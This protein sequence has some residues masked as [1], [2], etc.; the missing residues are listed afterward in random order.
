MANKKITDLTDIG[1][2]ANDD[3]LEIVDV[4]DLTDSP[5]GT[6][7][8]VLVSALGGGSTP[9]LQDVLDE[10][11]TADESIILT[12]GIDTTTINKGSIDLQF[13]DTLGSGDI[14]LI[15]RNAVGETLFSDVAN[16]NSVLMRIATPTGNGELNYPDVGN[17]I[18]TIA[19]REWVEDN[20][21]KIIVSE[22]NGTFGTHTG[23]TAETVLLAIDISANEFEAGDR[24]IFKI[25]TDKSAGVENVQFRVRVGTTGTTS[26]LLI[27]TS[28][29][30]TGNNARYMMFDRQRNLFLTGNSLRCT[31]STIPSATDI[32]ALNGTSTTVTLNPS[33]AWKFV[34]TA[35]LSAGAETTNLV[36]YTISKIKSL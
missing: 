20:V 7:K 30:Y 11:N 5:E 29:N 14:F 31:S 25:F 34:I 16:A 4:S 8:K 1:T 36:G 23:N 10:G 17:N 33:N 3:L 22:S 2:P 13:D 18:E 35:Q 26:D 19:T 28:A 9:T 24:L 6:S 15:S 12:D 21:E 27:A 32:N